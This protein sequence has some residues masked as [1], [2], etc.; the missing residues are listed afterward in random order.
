[1][2]LYIPPRAASR[3]AIVTKKGRLFRGL[4]FGGRAAKS[5]GGTG[6]FSS[7][8]GFFPP[9]A[10]HGGVLGFRGKKKNWG[11]ER[12]K[13]GSGHFRENKGKKKLLFLARFGGK[14]I[15]R[16][17]GGILPTKKGKK[18]GK[19]MGGSTK[20]ARPRPGF[21]KGFDSE[22]PL[23]VF[24]AGARPGEKPAETKIISF[25]PKTG[26]VAGPRR[27]PFGSPWGAKALFS[28]VFLGG[29]LFSPPTRQTNRLGP[30]GNFVG[31]GKRQNWVQGMGVRMLISRAPPGRGFPKGGGRGRGISG[32]AWEKK[33]GGK[34]GP[35]GGPGG[36]GGPG[37]QTFVGL[38]GISGAGNRTGGGGAGWGGAM[39][40]ATN[41]GGGAARGLGNSALEFLTKKN[42][43]SR[44]AG[45]AG[46]GFMGELVWVVRDREGKWVRR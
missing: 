9:K 42:A 21:R 43:K 20:T 14:K 36:G 11:G 16:G 10:G 44:A 40:P 26:G 34:R 23:R 27:N 31:R 15:P 24:G 28:M 2:R 4:A 35:G 33:G 45:G 32:G 22:K 12:K 6:G 18:G 39:D 5:G 37:T 29:G 41:G 7:G 3:F 13:G 30:R 8:G 17:G 19:G 1:M 25:S 46:E 38:R